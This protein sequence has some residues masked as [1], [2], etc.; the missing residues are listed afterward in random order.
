MLN[1][2]YN[3]LTYL[4]ESFGNLV[5]LQSLY[6]D[7]NKLTELPESFG[8]LVGLTR[9]LVSNNQFTPSSRPPESIIEEA[10]EQISVQ[11]IKKWFEKNPVDQMDVESVSITDP[12]RSASISRICV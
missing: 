3:Q 12:H 7:S 9:L 2:S 5:G 1:L 6:L 4:P 10:D 8:Q 11:P